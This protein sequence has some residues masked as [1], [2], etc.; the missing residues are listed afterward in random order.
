MVPHPLKNLACHSEPV[1]AH[2]SLI[3]SLIFLCVPRS[4]P[5][6][7]FLNDFH[8]TVFCLCA[9]TGTVLSLWHAFLHLSSQLLPVF[10]GSV[11][12]TSSGS[13][14]CALLSLC[15]QSPFKHTTNQGIK[16]TKKIGK[17]TSEHVPCEKLSIALLYFSYICYVHWVTT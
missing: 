7:V 11:E 5:V 6:P 8:P 14:A 13:L 12:V 16:Q 9:F 17:K 10:Q 4:L 3:S 2:L 1:M 15:T